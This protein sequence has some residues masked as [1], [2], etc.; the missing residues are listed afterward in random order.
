[1]TVFGLSLDVTTDQ[2]VKVLS[3]FKW[4]KITILDAILAIYKKISFYIDVEKFRE[5]GQG[6]THQG[7][8][9]KRSFSLCWW[10]DQNFSM[11]I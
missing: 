4:R 5:I 6:R 3:P 11:Q 7:R 10:S 9:R 1:M 8:D 2:K